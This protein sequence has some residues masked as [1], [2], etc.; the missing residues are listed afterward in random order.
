VL[1]VS[2]SGTTT[3]IVFDPRLFPARGDLTMR[4]LIR[5]YLLFFSTLLLSLLA[6]PAVAQTY[7]WGCALQGSVWNSQVVHL[8]AGSG[9]ILG[10]LP[11]TQMSA[12]GS[13]AGQVFTSQ[14][15]GNAPTWAAIAV[16]LGSPT[17]RSLSLATAYQA[18]NTAKAAMVVVTLNSSAA[19]TLTTGQTHTAIVV[20]GSTN[21]VASGTGTTVAT[22][23][24]SLSGT[25]TVGLAL[26]SG[27]SM[28][29]TFALPAGWYFAVLQQTGTVS[30]LSAFDQAVG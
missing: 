14:G 17:S 19:I 26:T 9:C 24:N 3:S 10:N 16:P 30:I 28:P 6:F 21:A 27:S 1:K 18:S 25:L 8:D 11:A 23:S 4:R 22:Y 29:V 15:S 20:I 2:W 5:F 12:T 13:T 7:E